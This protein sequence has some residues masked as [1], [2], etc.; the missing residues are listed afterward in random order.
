[1][2]RYGRYTIVPEAGE[3]HLDAETAAAKGP[4]YLFNK[5]N[6]RLAKARSSSRSR[7]RLL[8]TAMS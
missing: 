6:E 8:R 1:V 3:E 5:L 4:D 2:S 7:F